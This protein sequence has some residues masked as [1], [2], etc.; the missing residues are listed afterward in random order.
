VRNLAAHPRWLPGHIRQHRG[1]EARYIL[2]MTDLV[3]RR[4]L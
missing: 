2:E 4:K 3:R 1:I